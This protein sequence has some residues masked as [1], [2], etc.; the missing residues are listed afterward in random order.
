MY[1]VS[2]VCGFHR[3]LSQ[4]KYYKIDICHF[5]TNTTHGLTTK[6]E[7]LKKKY[8]K[9]N[10]DIIYCTLHVSRIT[11]IRY[12]SRIAFIRYVSRITLIRYFSRI[13]F[14]R[15]VSI[16]SFIRSQSRTIWKIN[17]LKV[18]GSKQMYELVVVL[19]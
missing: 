4:T 3:P 13:T 6:F 7:K 11:F 14:I 2:D 16:I 17:N 15:Y 5:Y 19:T 18:F 10:V 1:W 12:V 8:L 9:K